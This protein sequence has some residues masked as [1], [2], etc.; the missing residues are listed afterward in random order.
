MIRVLT[1]ANSLNGSSVNNYLA[2]EKSLI[3][4]SIYFGLTIDARKWRVKNKIEWK[5]EMSQKYSDDQLVFVD[6]YD[7]LFVGEKDELQEILDLSEL[8]FP[9]DAGPA[10]WP[11]EYYEYSYNKRRK[12]TSKWRYLNGSGPAGLGK[13]IAESIKYGFLH[14]ALKERNFDQGWWSNIYLDGWGELDQNCQ[15]TQNIF[16][17]P[18]HWDSSIVTK[19]GDM[20]VRNGRYYN[21]ITGSRPQFLHAMGGTWDEIPEELIPGPEEVTPNG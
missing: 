13:V 21:F 2:L 10:P 15:L 3:R 4:K 16:K 9:T 20:G 14:Y 7:M 8:L 6:A 17:H 19:S 1:Y 12:A 11:Y 18:S 5:L